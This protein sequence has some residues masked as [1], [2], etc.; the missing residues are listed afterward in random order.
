L[1]ANGLKVLG[2]AAL[3]H[4]AFGVPRLGVPGA[5]WSSVLARSVM[6]AILV[7]YAI[8]HSDRHNTGLRRV[9]LT[10]DL[11]RLRR[12]LG[13]GLPSAVQVTLEVGVFG[14]AALLAGRLGEVA[15]AAHEVVLN[16]TCVSFMVPLGVSSAASVR[17]GQALG[18]RDPP[19]A[20][21]A[22]WV[23]IGV[24]VGFMSVCS[25]IL[26][27]I[28]GVL[29][30]PFTSA[31]DVVRTAL[32]LLGTAACFQLFDGLQ[33]VATGSL[34]GL[35]STATSM[36]ANL[37]GHWFIGLPV[38]YSLAFPLGLGVNGLWLG[39]ASGLISCGILQLVAWT[40]AANRIRN[41]EEAEPIS[42]PQPTC[43]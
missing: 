13:L 16:I 1:A 31:P 15:L 7:G 12:L 26:L 39:L 23:A 18:R 33:V 9:A 3:V 34:R 21:R 5:G 30:S 2:N 32:P 28:P 37:A 24:S 38:G 10:A 27:T 41:E 22:G 6:A 25:L 17:V 8:W 35:G 29:L 36:F 4:G 43:V 20:I 14:A 19:G 42:A 40:H 11:A